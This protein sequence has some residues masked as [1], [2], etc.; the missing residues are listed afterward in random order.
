MRHLFR[1]IDWLMELPGDLIIEF[2][3]QIA[4]YQEEKRMPFIDTFEKIGMER[5]LGKGIEA[6]LE[7][8]FGDASSQ[9][10]SGDSA[11]P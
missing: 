2:D 3:D 6:V 8:R 5:G 1:V 11:D 9:L 4:K 10:M 7:V